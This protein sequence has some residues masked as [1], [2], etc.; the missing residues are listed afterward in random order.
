MDIFGTVIAGVFVFVLGQFVLK[1]IIEP[2]VEA[3]RTIAKIQV[4]QQKFKAI[5]CNYLTRDEPEARAIR[6]QYRE[7][8]GQ[9]LVHLR[10]IPLYEYVRH[11]AKLPNEADVESASRKL[12]EISNY[13]GHK[14]GPSK[15]VEERTEQLNSLLNI[16]TF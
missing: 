16:K 7:Y 3:H 4:D 10:V 9:L 15:E 5:M 2:I 14:E 11:I 13:I 8:A 6:A 1:L 12:I